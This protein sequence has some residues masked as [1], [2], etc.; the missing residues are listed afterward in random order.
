MIKKIIV[1][2]IFIVIVIGILVI[3]IQSGFLVTDTEGGPIRFFPWDTDQLTIGWRHSVELT[4]WEE[5]YRIQDNGELS[6]ESSTYQAY[7]AGTPDTEG[8]VEFL[9][10]G[11]IRVT[12]IERTLPYFS[13]FYVPISN[14]YLESDS[15]KYPLSEF[16]PDDTKVQIHFKRLRIYQWLWLKINLF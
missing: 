6:F 12:G 13:L 14:Y 2:C 8:N 3:P 10:N 11:F 7:G 4:P 1:I 9:S 15:E 16:V 5:T